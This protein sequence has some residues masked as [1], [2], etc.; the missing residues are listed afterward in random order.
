MPIG[1]DRNVTTASTLQCSRHYLPRHSSIA[2]IVM[3]WRIQNLARSVPAQLLMQAKHCNEVTAGASNHKSVPN[4]VRVAHP[5]IENKENN[6][7]GVCNAA[8]D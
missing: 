6:A 2:V 8:S 4:G 3:S 1:N 7:Y 5:R